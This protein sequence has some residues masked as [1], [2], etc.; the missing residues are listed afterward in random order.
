MAP[1]IHLLAFCRAGGSRGT[2]RREVAILERDIADRGNVVNVAD[3]DLDPAPLAVSAVRPN[4]LELMAENLHR[5]PL[6]FLRLGPVDKR[7]NL[8][9]DGH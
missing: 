8:L 3:G 5:E 7:E 4:C 1:V 2:V 9:V 6:E